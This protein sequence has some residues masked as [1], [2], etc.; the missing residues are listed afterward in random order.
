MS[1]SYNGVTFDLDSSNGQVP[2]WDGEHHVSRHHVPYSNRDVVQS[3]GFGNPRL[4]LRALVYSE[5][6]VKALQASRGAEG[7]SWTDPHG[8]TYPDAILIAARPLARIGTS[9]YWL[10]ELT[11]EREGS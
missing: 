8:A 4:T 5:A 7:R 9:D 2:Y 3:G 1:L 11:F 10:M 6:D